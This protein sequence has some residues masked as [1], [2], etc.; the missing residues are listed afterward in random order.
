MSNFSNLGLE[1]WVVDGLAQL[2]ITE[3]T[4]IQEK[5]IPEALAGRDVI[6]QAPT[7][8]GKTVAFGAPMASL[9]ER[10]QQPKSPTGLVLVPTRELALQVAKALT[11]YAKGKLRV[12]AVYGGTPYGPQFRRLAEG[13]DTVVATPGRLIDL[14]DRRQVL[15]DKVAIVTVDEI[16]R[17]SDMGFAPALEEILSSLPERVQTLFF[18]ATLDS[19]IRR[20]TQ[21]YQQDPVTVEVVVESRPVEHR[22]LRVGR[23]EKAQETS[24]LIAGNGRTIVFCNT[25]E[26]VERLDRELVDQGIVSVQVHGGRSQQQRERA[27]RR[28]TGD[29][30]DALIATDVAARGIHVD[31]VE[32]VVHFDIPNSYTDYLHRSG[33]TGRAG[34]SGLVVALVGDSDRGRA[35]R[36]ER[37]LNGERGPSEQRFRSGPRGR[38]AGRDRM[39][40]R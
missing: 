8:S 7:G 31:A 26:Q 28:F 32:L 12:L 35:S 21:R 24:K 2:G 9:L 14:L 20:M 17:M 37:M 29:K 27:I 25:R 3:P 38:Y 22:F 40:S 23:Y 33:R 13:V 39:G 16:D 10:A 1:E 4:E 11:S 6:G 36:I 34:R 30:A 19:S 18:S 5:T 15:L